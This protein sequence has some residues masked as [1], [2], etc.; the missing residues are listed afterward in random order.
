MR[1][2]LIAEDSVAGGNAAD[3]RGEKLMLKSVSKLFRN[4]KQN[5]LFV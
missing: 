3:A 1:N 5:Q 2:H 4:E